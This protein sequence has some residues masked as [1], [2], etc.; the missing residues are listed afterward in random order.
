VSTTVSVPA[1]VTKPRSASLPGRALGSAFSFPVAVGAA[2]CAL[3]V[4][5]SRGRFNDPEMWRHLKIGEFIW[6]THTIPA[7]HTFSPIPGR[8]IPQ[9][10]LS[11]LA[12]FGAYHLGGFSG[13]IFAFCC[14]AAAVLA[15]GY[16]LC[17][18]YG[19]SPRAAF[20]GA[21]VLFLFAA[22]GFSIRPQLI[23]YLLLIG[24]LVILH[25]GRIRNP[26]WF[27]ALPPLFAVWANCHGSFL[28]GLAVVAAVLFSSFFDFEIGSLIAEPW[29]PVRRRVLSIALAFSALAALLNPAGIRQYLYALDSLLCQPIDLAVVDEWSP[30]ELSSLRG[31][32]FLALLG[33]ILLL[34]ILRK[35]E[36]Y[37]DELVL[38]AL[39]VWLGGSQARQLFVFGILAAPILSRML[40][41]SAHPWDRRKN[42][43]LP[44][45]LLIAAASVTAVAAFPS[46]RNINSQIEAQSP[47]RAVEYMQSHQLAGSILTE[48]RYGGYLVW[49]MPGHPIFVDGRTGLYQWSGVPGQYELRAAM[50]NDHDA[51]LD[52]YGIQFCLLSAQSPMAHSLPADQWKSVYAGNGSILFQRIPGQK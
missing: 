37:L 45:A 3:A 8:W 2:L 4:V 29:R 22:T 16:A 36:L 25:L 10:W 42:R 49:A 30:L 26:R 34:L 21:L 5:T 14:L 18:V 38:L 44:N 15:G 41:N 33:G 11:Q 48:Y 1:V 35:S 23:G 9:E 13:M 20:P 7:V 52:Q 19:R 39:A 32:C 40:A 47:A 51:A 31:A 27:L 12:I 46:P 28:I 50:H 6:T 43:V 24:E 17:V